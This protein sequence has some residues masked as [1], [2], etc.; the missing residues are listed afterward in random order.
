MLQN[1][2]YQYELT[3]KLSFTRYGGTEAEDRAAD[4]LLAE[5]EKMGGKGEKMPFTIPAFETL[6]CKAR[7]TAPFETELECVPLGLAGDFPEG[8]VDLKLF[9]AERGTELDY[10]GMSDLSGYAVVISELTT[11]AYKLLC[12]KKA[13]AFITTQGKYYDSQD[14]L[15][16]ISRHLR[17]KFLQHGKVPGFIMRASAVTEFIRKHAETIHLDLR[18][19]EYMA[20]SRNVLAVIPGKSKSE[21]SV[22]ITAHYDS[23]PV[24]T[25]SWD[26]ATG[27]AA[28]MY[29]YEHFLHNPPE[30]TLRFIWC[31]S[32]EQGLLGS[33]AYIEQNPELVKQIKFC[34]NFDMNGT[35]LGP[36]NIVVTG[37]EKLETLVKQYCDE[38][39]F[40]ASMR[41]DM[42]SS[43]SAPF[44]DKGI[45][46]VGISRGTKTAEIHTRHDLM[47]PLSAEAMAITTDF[48]IPFMTRIINSVVMPIGLGMPKD[49]QETLDKRFR[50]DADKK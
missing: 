34:F 42:H 22:V 29:I 24:G 20:Q 43:D 15:D 39:G 18:T 49:I 25:G 2:T 17:P 10:R 38:V 11:D 23:I 28:A 14:T 19:R 46:G 41:R 7:I 9:Y 21:E 45:P 47:W 32:E 37:D 4:I 3:E 30:R 6:E 8:G 26:N 12:Q 1:G 13:T 40:S 27:S 50:L 31:G 33:L 44:A 16:L 35:V 48:A 5:I 36:N